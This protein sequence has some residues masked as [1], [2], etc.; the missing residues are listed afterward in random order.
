MKYSL[1]I[2]VSLLVFALFINCNP[3]K[4]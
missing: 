4:Y 3:D 1:G 2:F